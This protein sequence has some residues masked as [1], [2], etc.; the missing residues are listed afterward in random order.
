MMLTFLLALV[1]AISIPPK[2][3]GYLTDNAHVMDAARAHAL[4]EKLAQFERDTSNQLL[5]YVDRKLPPDTTI[6]QFAN[7]AIH[8]WGVGQKGKDNG[9]VLFL[10]IDD[11]KM[12][13][14]VGY[15]L[16]ATLTDA[17]SRNITSTI[18]KP[19]LKKQDYTGAAEAGASAMMETARGEPSKGTGKTVHESKPVSTSGLALGFFILAVIVGLPIVVIVFLVR[20]LIRRPRA[21]RSP[22][23]ETPDS[24]TSGWSGWTSGSS[25]DSSSSSSESSSSFDGG[26]GDSGGG[27]AS[28]SW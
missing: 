7:E 23:T 3:A 4:N 2:P 5:V 17:R 9:A 10:F 22:R 24:S 15:G 14:E 25:S 26:G 20:W 27:G 18:I 6:E 21:P 11:R 19:Y 8:Q 1:T 13:I 16:E 28:D 12:R